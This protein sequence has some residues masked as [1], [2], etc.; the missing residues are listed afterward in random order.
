MN[1][2]LAEDAGFDFVSFSDPLHP[3]LEAQGHAPFAW[4]VL[5]AMTYG[6]DAEKHARGIKTFV[7]AGYNRIALTGV[8]PDQAGFIN[9]IM[10]RLRPALEKML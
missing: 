3:W 6:P 1:A 7:D 10:R 8:G 5:G 4:S 2:K 9:F